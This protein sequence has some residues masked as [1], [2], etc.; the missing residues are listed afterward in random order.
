[1][2][3]LAKK[4]GKFS[5][6]R[7]NKHIAMVVASAMA[8]LPV[9]LCNGL[10][11]GPKWTYIFYGIFYFVVITLELL[12][13]PVGDK[14]LALLHTTRENKV[15]NVIRILKTWIIIFLGELFFQ[16]ASLREGFRM[17]KDIASGFALKKLWAGSYPG[18]GLDK[19]DWL[20]VL[21]M[22]IAVIIIN[23][24]REKGVNVADALLRKNILVRWALLFSLVMIIIIF[25]CYGPGF[26]E[27]DLI[28]AGF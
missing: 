20:L 23:I 26:E 5:R 19:Y 27:V 4:W 24:L 21:V 17:V 3:S 13:E 25:G 18:W 9:W 7:V 12:L 6:K 22:L 2:S 16:A 10:W 1:M 14:M 28:Y 11:H 15:V 8:L